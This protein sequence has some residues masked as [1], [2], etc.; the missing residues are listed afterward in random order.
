MEFVELT[1]EEFESAKFGA[2]NFLQDV[3][4]Y[5]RQK[6]M[7]HDTFLVGVRDAEGKIVAKGVIMTHEWYL[8]KKLCRVPGGW[9]MDYDAENWREVLD[10]LTAQAKK[11]CAR[12]GGIVIEISPNIVSQERNGDNNVVEGGAEHLAVKDEL[13]K[14]GYKYLG[15][16]ECA[17]WTY[18]LDV[19][20]KTADELF[21]NFR[22]GH[23]AVIKRAIRDGVKVRELGEDE[24]D[25]L[26]GIVA[27]T[28]KRQGFHA[29]EMAYYQ[30]M[31]KYFGDKV[32]NMVAELPQYILDGKEKPED[33]KGEKMVPIAA[34]M[35]VKSGEE[36]VYSCSGS[37]PEYRQYGAPHL[38]QWEMIQR[39][40]KGEYK[41]YN[42][43][44]MKPVSGS[45]VYNFKRGFRGYVR[46]MLGMF[47]LPIG[48]I[49]RIYVAHLKEVTYSCIEGEGEN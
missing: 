1:E 4:M 27:E 34:S 40:T 42:F 36:L 5:R 3:R 22:K 37:K 2:D 20:N 33:G 24:L 6:A 10:F 18:A 44:G 15:E 30:T 43:Y 13:K 41:R 14:L 9:V 25:V 39:A 35:F 21:K 49:G 16:Y 32:I 31:K 28:A 17:K 12:R 7:G 38:I 29:P 26:D 11:F 46:E 47:A 45:G 23:K 8:G 19:E 48:L